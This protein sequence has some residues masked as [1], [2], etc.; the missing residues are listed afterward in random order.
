MGPEKE[1]PVRGVTEREKK[2]AYEKGEVKEAEMRYK[3]QC[4][5]KMVCLERIE[6]ENFYRENAAV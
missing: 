6:R 1:S 4:V 3:M 5:K 2:C